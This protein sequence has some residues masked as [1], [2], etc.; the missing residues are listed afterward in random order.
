MIELPSEKVIFLVS[1]LCLLFF[2]ICIIFFISQNRYVNHRIRLERETKQKLIDSQEDE[3]YRIAADLHDNMGIR[4]TS[5]NMFTEGIKFCL[6]DIQQ[7]LHDPQYLE[8]KMNETHALL[9]K[10]IEGNTQS[11]QNLRHTIYAITPFKMEEL[12]LLGSLQELCEQNIG[13]SMSYDYQYSQTHLTFSKNA[14]VAIYRI[15]QELINNTLKH[16]NA[17]KI[18]LQVIIDEAMMKIIYEDNGKGISNVN[19][20]NAGF[21]M[22]TLR[23]RTEQ[24][25]GKISLSSNEPRGVRYTLVFNNSEIKG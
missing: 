9:N 5:M 25:K 3:R 24:L 8:D 23:L 18:N 4:F 16:A 14:Q 7:H 2:I 12:G 20:H 11:Y 17:S 13:S 10:V 19:K 22:Q 15:V 6:N 1:I 21:G